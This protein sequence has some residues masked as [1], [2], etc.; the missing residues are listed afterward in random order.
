MNKKGLISIFG[1][2]VILSLAFPIIYAEAGNEIILGGLRVDQSAILTSRD[3]MVYLGAFQVPNQSDPSNPFTTNWLAV[4]NASGFNSFFQVGLMGS[5]NGSPVLQWF[6]EAPYG[7]T[8][9]CLRGTY[10]PSINACYGNAYDLVALG[11]FHKVELVTY[12]QQENGQYFWIARVVETNGNSHDVAKVYFSQAYAVTG[13]QVS[14]E[15]GW[16]DP[17]PDPHAA[18]EFIQYLPKY[19]TGAGD[20]IWPQTNLPTSDTNRSWIDIDQSFCPSYL[21]VTPNY[22]ENEYA[23]LGGT[24]GSGVCDW[25]LFPPVSFIGQYDDY[26]TNLIEY[27]PS[28]S[29]WT[30]ISPAN[31]ALFDRITKSSSNYNDKA[32]FTFNGDTITYFYTTGVDRGHQSILLDGVDYDYINS[33]TSYGWRRQIAKTWSV[34]GGDHTIEI[35]NDDSGSYTDIDGFEVNIATVSAGTYDDSDISDLKYAGPWTQATGISGAY[36][37]T[38][39]WSQNIGSLMRLTFTGSS[40]SF[41]YS[42]AYNR[43]LAGV[44]IDGVTQADIDLYSPT[45]Q[46]HVCYPYILNY[47]VHNINIMVTG[48]KN[49][50]SSG[51]FISID[52]L[53]VQ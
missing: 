21:S 20:L 38:E 36:N 35:I 3:Y 15:E 30:Q 41:C 28:T 8:I 24:S 31:Y 6:F 25:I 33:H 14:V 51:I 47:D 52:D 19:H 29:H 23:W 11:E 46:R 4:T 45:V 39:H 53:V 26:S 34:Y 13:V 50:Y 7:P 18:A 43:G 40:I 2:L 10:L 1:L 49:S 16:N 48:H 12:D 44:T 37:G 9:R 22:S 42:K 27:I 32:R 17:Y 5:Y